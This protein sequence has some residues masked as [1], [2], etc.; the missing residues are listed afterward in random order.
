MFASDFR[1][2]LLVRRIKLVSTDYVR[3][4]VRLSYQETLGENQEQSSMQKQGVYCSS[5]LGSSCTQRRGHPFSFFH[6]PF[7]QFLRTD[8]SNS[9]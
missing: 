9:N 4:K 7:K 2:Q 5:A 8:Y 1:V 3:L 6:T